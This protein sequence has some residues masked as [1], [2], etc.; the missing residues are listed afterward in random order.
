MCCYFS[1]IASIEKRHRY[2]RI[3]ANV[4]TV[5]QPATVSLVPM[6]WMKGKFPVMFA[7]LRVIIETN[8]IKRTEAFF[9]KVIKYIEVHW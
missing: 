8:D 6:R 9:S 5:R 2:L 7:L 3:M 1:I 4:D